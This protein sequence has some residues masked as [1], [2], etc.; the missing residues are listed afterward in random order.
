MENRITIRE[1]VTENDV[2]AFG[3]S[4]MPIT[5][6]TFSPTPMMTSLNTFSAPG[7]MTA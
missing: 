7:I 5:S 4:F 2:D 3:S 1:A 6:G